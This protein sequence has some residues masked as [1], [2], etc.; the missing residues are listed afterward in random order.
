MANTSDD[1]LQFRIATSNDAPKLQRLLEAAFRAEDSR[2]DWTADMAL[3]ERFR[4]DLSEV[5]QMIAK[6]D[7]T[8]LIA[9]TTTTTDNGDGDNE[10]GDAFVACCGLQKRGPNLARFGP[11]AVDTQQ[12]QRGIGRRVLAY[13]E[14]YCRR[15]LDVQR[16]EMNVLSTRPQ[17]IAWY[18]RCGYR[19]TGAWEPFPYD[20]FEDLALP[21]DL[22]LVMFEKDL[23]EHNG[24]AALAATEGSG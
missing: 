16:L 21:E 13:A 15:T 2:K 8:I 4:M 11:F 24:K 19:K 17:L 10:D 12:Q 6:F 3:N 20:R 18:M 23:A 22:R 9:T 5:M 7:S 14:D 1:N